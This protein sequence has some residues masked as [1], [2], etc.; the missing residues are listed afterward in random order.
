MKVSL[1]TEAL[2]VFTRIRNSKVRAMPPLFLFLM[3]V[4]ADISVIDSIKMLSICLL[5]V[6]AGSR[7]LE[8]FF[9]RRPISIFEKYGLGLPIGI[10]ISVPFDLIFSQTSLSLVAW[11]FP[12][13]AVL[14]VAEIS[15]L[16]YSRIAV[17]ELEYDTDDLAWVAIGV[18]AI[19]A[20]EWFWLMP[21]A[22]FFT[23]SRFFHLR[24]PVLKT[25]NKSN[26][27]SSRVL[28]GLGLAALFAAINLR[29]FS[30]WIEDSDFGFYESYSISLSNWGLGEN[31]LAEGTGFRYHWLVY[32]WSGLVTKVGG[33]S[34][35]VMISRGSIIL[36]SFALMCLIWTILNR[37][38]QNRRA[39][40][41]S[42]MLV[43]F[44]D[45]VVSWGAGF[46]LG[47][48]SSPSQLI[49]LIW[50]F[51]ILAVLIEQEKQRVSFSWLLYALL[52]SGAILSKIS[53]GIVAIGG[54]VLV[55]FF[56]SIRERKVCHGRSADFFAAIGVLFFWY[57]HTFSG[58]GISK[59]SFLKFPEQM[60]G[61]LYQWDGR[62]LWFAAAVLLIGLVAFP[63]FGILNAFFEIYFRSNVLVLFVVGAFLVGTL[64]A[65]G[66]DSIFGSQL[67]FLHSAT[68][69]AV[70]LASVGVVDSAIYLVKQNY[71]LIRIRAICV[72]G[73]SAALVSWLIPT[74]NSGS[75]T[76]TWLAVSRSGVFV[77]PCLSALVLVNFKTLKE[78]TR[79]FV[80]L[81]LIGLCAMS[82]GF[83]I[84]NWVMISKRETP[85]FDRNE[86]FNLGTPDLREAMSWMRANSPKD[87]IFI[88]NNKSFLLSALSHRR[89]YSQSEDL[90]RRHIA[91]QSK[92]NAVLDSRIELL[93]RVT[94]ALTDREVS[95]LKVDQVFWIVLDKSVPDFTLPTPSEQLK[96]SFENRSILIFEIT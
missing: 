21:V 15:N 40:I 65:L 67:Y 57:W 56:E 55:A 88:S 77:I 6:F 17:A 60:L 39:A 79:Q 43:Y 73:F 32:E 41:V 11:I 26:R 31:L 80:S 24:G 87:A 33:L 16:N 50:L 62:P 94:N 37:V 64:V 4:L 52:F 92:L 51:A 8:R 95:Q 27:V 85:S 3:F 89:G 30:W 34:S 36:A 93:G 83:S 78:I 10:L 82:I 72:I 48:I 19:L 2:D 45:T 13:L 22:V 29:P 28:F 12:V 53:H 42:M 46:R 47:F 25:K 7:L 18:M 20:P 58:A 68:S 74:V 71:S 38:S 81:C 14:I 69:V 91:V 66:L 96:K 54:F 84:S 76:A 90:V 44:F 86:N 9:Y 63:F 70:V 49:G 61:V 75:E 35:W 59:I 23:L 1:N 5:Q